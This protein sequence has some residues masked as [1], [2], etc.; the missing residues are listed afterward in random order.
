M[1][2]GRGR[3]RGCPSSEAEM[4]GCKYAGERARVRSREFGNVRS[5]DVQ[6]NGYSSKDN[7]T[8]RSRVGVLSREGPFS[9]P[10]AG[11]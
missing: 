10:Y 4:Y 6:M 7:A 8:L 5:S 3:G 11:Y 1:W 2:G 9:G